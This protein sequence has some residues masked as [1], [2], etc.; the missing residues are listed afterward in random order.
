ML[1]SDRLK[2]M[3]AI[4]FASGSRE[5]KIGQTN[6]HLLPFLYTIAWKCY[7]TR[8][9]SRR[10]VIGRCVAMQPVSCAQRKTLRVEPSGCCLPL[11]HHR[12]S[13]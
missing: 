11:H 2:L 9:A 10:L 8:S 6:T 3:L 5:D 4:G 12:S 13:L 1:Q 7:S